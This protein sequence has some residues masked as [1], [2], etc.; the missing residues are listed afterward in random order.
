VQE[1]EEERRLCYVGMTRAKERLIM[2]RAESR[3][4]HGSDFYPQ[5]SRFLRELPPELLA[6]VRL[7]GSVYPSPRSSVSEASSSSGLRLG[8]RVV[9]AKF[10][11]GVVLQIEGGGNDTRVQVNFKGV[12]IKWLIAAYAGLTAA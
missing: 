11:E 1:L 4:L 7:G 3:R 6:E 8:Q 9:H 12:G 2:T 5:A 10:G